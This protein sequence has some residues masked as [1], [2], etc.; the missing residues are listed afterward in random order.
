MGGD[1]CVPDH[2]L[3]VDR[4]HKIVLFSD[5]TSFSAYDEN[6][7]RWRTDVASDEATLAGVEGDDVVGFGFVNG[8]EQHPI[9]LN[10][11]TSIP[12]S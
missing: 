7:L 1:R 3:L 8:V 5:F 4:E 10:L 9:R 11:A 2:R 6:G 12:S